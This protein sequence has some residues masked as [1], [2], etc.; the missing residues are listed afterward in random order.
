MTYREDLELLGITEDDCHNF[1][2]V[3][4][5]ALLKE[6]F[7]ELAHRHHPDLGGDVDAFQRCREAYERVLT[8]V[9]EYT[10]DDKCTECN[11]E[12]VVYIHST[13]SFA[14]LKQACPRGCKSA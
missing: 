5:E 2:D 10:S 6:K 4:D 7:R 11:G 13:T 14:V 8:E 3:P 1:D 12:G 9:R